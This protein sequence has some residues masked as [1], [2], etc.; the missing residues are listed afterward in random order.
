MPGL[1]SAARV[2]H[3]CAT[4]RMHRIVGVGR[5]AILTFLPLRFA[6]GDPTVLRASPEPAPTE[7]PV[8]AP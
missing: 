5:K 1:G 2:A 4:S 7:L 3:P 8:T 6:G